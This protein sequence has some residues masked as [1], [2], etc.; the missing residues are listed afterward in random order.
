MRMKRRDFVDIVTWS[1]DHRRGYH[2]RDS[3]CCSSSSSGRPSSATSCSPSTSDLEEAAEVTE[4]THQAGEV[5]EVQ[6]GQ[7][8]V[9][10]GRA[11]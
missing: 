1:S 10:E 9:L 3:C 11:E 2:G 8:R 4:V 5:R 7:M 6:A